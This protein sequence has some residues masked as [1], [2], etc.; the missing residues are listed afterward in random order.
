MDKIKDLT[1]ALAMLQSVKESDTLEEAH[2]FAEIALAYLEVR[3]PD[4]EAVALLTQR[5]A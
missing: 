2:A 4:P 5:P 1:V 3:R